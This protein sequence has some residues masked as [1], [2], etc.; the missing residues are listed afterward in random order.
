MKMKFLNTY[1]KKSA[2]KYSAVFLLLFLSFFLLLHIIKK[3]KIDNQENNFVQLYEEP[4][5]YEPI[6]FSSKDFVSEI[7]NTIENL[8]F[9]LD[10]FRLYKT[11][12]IKQNNLLTTKHKDIIAEKNYL[13]ISD[14]HNA[15]IYDFDGMLLSTIQANQNNIDKFTYIDAIKTYGDSVFI[16]CS[17]SNK[18]ILFNKNGVLIKIFKLDDLNKFSEPYILYDFFVYNE[19]KIVAYADIFVNPI[20]N[21]VNRKVLLFKIEGNDRTALQKQYALFK[22]NIKATY[23]PIVKIIKFKEYLLFPDNFHNS[24]YALSIDS[25]SLFLFYSYDFNNSDLLTDAFQYVEKDNDIFSKKL[26]DYLSDCSL[27]YSYY[28]E[29]IDDKYFVSFGNYWSFIYISQKLQTKSK[30]FLKNDDNEI[31]YRQFYDKYGVSIYGKIFFNNGFI[32]F[33]DY[34]MDNDFKILIFR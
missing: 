2:L 19:N 4:Q 25:D 7:E 11:I 29:A 30:V 5:I 23:S 16:L 32:I 28:F 17:S 33:T 15:Y 26:N 3:G 14:F 6:R 10:I 9:P 20:S 27:M 34:S 22:Y 1:L 13:I 8:K 21:F 12:T 24:I 18:I 31:L